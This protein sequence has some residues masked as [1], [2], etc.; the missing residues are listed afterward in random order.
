M[1]KI[2]IRPKS[3][4]QWNSSRGGNIKL[5]SNA[6]LLQIGFAKLEVKFEKLDIVEE[7]NKV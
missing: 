3:T 7:A 4:H 6:A 1:K 5:K 2:F